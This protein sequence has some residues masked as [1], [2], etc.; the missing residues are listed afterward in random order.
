MGLL[1]QVGVLMGTVLMIK[2]AFAVTIGL[3]LLGRLFDLDFLFQILGTA[4]LVIAM[5]AHIRCSFATF[6]EMGNP[7]LLGK[8]IDEPKDLKEAVSI[9]Q[10]FLLLG[11]IWRLSRETDFIK[12]TINL[13]FKSK[14]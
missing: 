1:F 9:R 6:S 3:V 14:D 4:Y 11:F 13:D 7:N 2:M 5:I 8:P 10:N 12:K